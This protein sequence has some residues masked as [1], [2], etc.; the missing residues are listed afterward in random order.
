MDADALAAMTD[1]ELR[2]V[3]S[4]RHLLPEPG[5]EVVGRLLATVAA[6][7]AERSALEVERDELAAQRD[8]FGQK[9]SQLQER[10]NGSQGR[11]RAEV[12]FE[13][14][15]RDGSIVVD[16]RNGM[17]QRV[18]LT[19]AASLVFE[20]IAPVSDFTPTYTLMVKQD[21]VGGHKLTW[22]KDVRWQESQIVDVATHPGWTSVYLIHRM[23]FGLC[24]R[25]AGNF[26]AT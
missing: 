21:A 6:L 25:G 24:A 1:E 20:P 17:S 23:S 12:M 8:A 15:A 16:Y 18:T 26:E 3:E 10:L 11:P 22:P 7:K 4:A 9:A 5:P 13:L 14:G 19:G 2:K